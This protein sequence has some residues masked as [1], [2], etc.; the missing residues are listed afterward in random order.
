MLHGRFVLLFPEKPRM[1]SPFPGMDPYIE[2]CG[3]WGDFHDALI[4]EI[5]R[6]V[7][8]VLPRGY[9]ARRG[10]RSYIELLDSEEKTEQHF[11]PDVT[12]PAPR[13]R[14]PTGAEHGMAAPGVAVSEGAESVVLRAFIEDYFV[15]RFIQWFLVK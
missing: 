2:A 5:S 8:E 9:V 3:L 10:R 12:I 7:S 11:E 15:E 14:K 4:A 13:Q 6:V 1:T